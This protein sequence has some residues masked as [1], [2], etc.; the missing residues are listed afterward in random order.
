VAAID[1]KKPD[2][3]ELVGVAVNTSVLRIEESHERALDR[4]AA[5]G[6]AQLAVSTG[7]DIENVSIA[8]TR[9]VVYGRALDVRDVQAAELG[10]LLWHIRYGGQHGLIPRAVKLYAR[11]LQQ[12]RR[13]YE[14]FI[15]E[16]QRALLEKFSARVMHEW[17]SDR[18]I[19]CGGSGKLE[20]TRQGGW[21]R[22]RGSMQRNA[23]F[24]VCTSCNGTRRAAISHAERIKWLAMTR[25]R[26]DAE[27]W[28]RRFEAAITWLNQHHAKRLTRPLTNQLERRKRHV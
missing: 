27:R 13:D 8:G 1:E 3:Q 26:Y 19:A 28:G 7:A 23:T 25:E 24:R 17:L 2:I 6:A 22:P 11:W 4:I 21:I 20:R 16:E 5:L 9:H 10:G 12:N 15:D 18:C 14:A